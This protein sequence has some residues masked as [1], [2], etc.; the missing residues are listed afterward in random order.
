MM[1]PLTIINR[2]R[3]SVRSDSVRRIMEFDYAAEN[4][5]VGIS[6]AKFEISDESITVHVRRQAFLQRD[7]HVKTFSF[8]CST[9]T[10]S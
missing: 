10:I 7:I 3:Q 9:L 4:R 8:V 2:H 5:L 1:F 6:S